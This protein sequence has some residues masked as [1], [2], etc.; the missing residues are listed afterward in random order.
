MTLES[1]YFGDFR[2]GLEQSLTERWRQTKISVMV[3]GPALQSQAPAGA[4]RRSI[5]RECE[6]YG[7]SIKG[8]H[9]QLVEI[10]KRVLGAGSNLCNYEMAVAKEV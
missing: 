1:P 7:T 3:L 10:H 2:D 4:L 6:T 8:E 9:T 5:I